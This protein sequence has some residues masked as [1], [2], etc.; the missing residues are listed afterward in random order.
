MHPDAPINDS[1]PWFEWDDDAIE[2]P[3]HRAFVAALRERASTWSRLGIEPA[4]TL[5]QVSPSLLVA[6]VDIDDPVRRRVLETVRADFAGTSLLL[7]HDSTGQIV[8]PLDPEDDK[9]IVRRD[10]G[11]TPAFFANLA[12]DWFEAEFRRPIERHEWNRAGFIHSRYVFADVG[13]PFLWS[14]S[15]RESRRDLVTPPDAVEVIR[16]FRDGKRQG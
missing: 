12:A 14:D 2:A 13:K 7:G 16:D 5:L 3:S 6:W 9:V 4:V 15:E 10:S 1:I 8:E 11:T